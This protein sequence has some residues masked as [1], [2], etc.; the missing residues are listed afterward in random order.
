MNQEH[1]SSA[2][3]K[4]KVNLDFDDISF[5]VLSGIL[6][7]VALLS[8]SVPV[9]IGAMILAPVFD[10]L[11]AVSF[12]I[13]G[14][15]WRLMLRG[16]GSSAV[17]LVLA[18]IACFVTVWAALYFDA[19][20]LAITKIGPDMVTERLTVGRHSFITALAAGAGGALASAADRRQNIVGV[21][22]ALA[23]VPAL[24]AAAIGFHYDLP[25]RWGGLILVAINVGGIILAG[26]IALFL[27]NRTK[28]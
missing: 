6:A 4:G 14:K 19:V 13:V 18:G 23:I 21:V 16:I 7:S 2:E 27:R 10:P 28:Q 26:L 8:N 3:F 11:I 22:I 20:P 12:G 17:L 25:N 9:L 15:D 5:I 1:N 24:A